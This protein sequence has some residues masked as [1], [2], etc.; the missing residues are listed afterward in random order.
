MRKT[1]PDKRTVELVRDR[2]GGICEICGWAESQQLHHRKA[3]GRGGSRDPL[4]N[5]PSNLVF[6]CYPCHASVESQ[7]VKAINEGHLI[8]QFNRDTADCIPVLYRG[9]WRVLNNEGGWMNC[10]GSL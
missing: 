1:G 6:I 9:T 7:R 8:S 4:I 2:A 5:A 3:R 10:P